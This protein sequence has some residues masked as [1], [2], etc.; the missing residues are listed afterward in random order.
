MTENLENKIKTNPS[1]MIMDLHAWTFLNFF[2]KI[3][4]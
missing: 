3:F 4:C 1:F 2:L